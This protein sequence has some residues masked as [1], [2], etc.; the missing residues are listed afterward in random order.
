MSVK[1]E[2]DAA[3]EVAQVQ[4]EEQMEIARQHAERANEVDTAPRQRTLLEIM[5]PGMVPANPPPY[6]KS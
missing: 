6:P 1:D 2:M 4:A 3:N 5:H